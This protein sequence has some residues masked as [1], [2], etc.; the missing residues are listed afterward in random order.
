MSLRADIERLEAFREALPPFFGPD[1]VAGAEPSA[2]VVRAAL[3]GLRATF[4]SL[5]PP[6]YDGRTRAAMELAAM[7]IGAS[8]AH[9]DEV[10]AIGLEAVSQE[11]QQVFA[12]LLRT[13]LRDEVFDPIL[14]SLDHDDPEVAARAI[15]L[16]RWLFFGASGAPLT[17]G[18]AAL[19]NAEVQM[20]RS[21]ASAPALRSA[22]HHWIPVVARPR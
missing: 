21:R 5:P 18:Q 12:P 7:V 22:V 3:S 8:G 13:A 17:E 2:E 15:S 6:P 9:H 19:I 10:F 11:A 14:L 20:L 1:E 16:A 4:A